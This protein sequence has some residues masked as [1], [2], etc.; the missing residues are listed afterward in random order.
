MPSSE[1]TRAVYVRMPAR[2]AAKLDRASAK[3]G[4][5]KRDV[6]AGLVS[7]HL[8]IEG[9]NVV[10]RPAPSVPMAW[11]S[12]EPEAEVLDLAEAARLLRVAEDEMERLAE[13]GEIPGRRIGGEWRFSREALLHWLRGG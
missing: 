9:E 12:G 11:S 1:P 5:S 2:V 6:L 7:D 10:L 13:S 3:L 4:I 8:D